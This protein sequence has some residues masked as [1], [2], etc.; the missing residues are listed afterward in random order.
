[1]KGMIVQRLRAIGVF[2]TRDE[3]E[4]NEKSSKTMYLL[5]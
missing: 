4:K 1:M 2:K 5:N 3:A